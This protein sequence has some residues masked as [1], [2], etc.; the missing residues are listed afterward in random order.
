[1]MHATK[2]N[3]QW[4][5]MGGGEGGSHKVS[6]DWV[7]TNRLNRPGGFRCWLV[8]AQFKQH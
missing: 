2:N 6:S 5:T 8:A 3:S 1:M 4:Q 7:H